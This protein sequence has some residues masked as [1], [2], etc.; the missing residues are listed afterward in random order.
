MIGGSRVECPADLLERARSHQPLRTAVVNAVHPTVLESVRDAVRAGVIEPILVGAPEDIKAAA[1]AVKFDI[2]RCE[3]VAAAGEEGSA[4]E[5]ARL[6]ASGAAGAVMKGHL[7]TDIFMRA[8]L[9]RDAGLRVG[10][11][12]THIFHMTLPGRE[13]AL[14][15]SDAALNPAPDRELKQTIIR[16]C[17]GLLKALG[18]ARPR[19]ALMS[20]T[21]VPS[22]R[23]PSSVDAAWLADWA[24]LQVPEADVAGPLALDLAVSEEAARIKGVGGPVAGRA[25]AIVVPEIVAGNALFK[26]M[27]QMMG[28]CAAGV[29]LGAK[30]PIMLVSRADPPAARLASAALASIARRL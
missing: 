30:V 7:H 13:G 26:V 17:V 14:L 9:S 18:T 4:S 23:I 3:I 5:G 6:A 1:T 27:V 15:I 19:I 24:R 22:E 25:D 28:A 21:E 12:F 2:S 20:A 10:R 29:V 11:P 16:N 8:L